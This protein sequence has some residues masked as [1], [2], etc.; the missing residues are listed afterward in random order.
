MHSMLYLHDGNAMPAR[1]RGRRGGFVRRR[2]GRRGRRCSAASGRPAGRAALRHRATGCATVRRATSAAVHRTTAHQPDCRSMH[3]PALR[4]ALHHPSVHPALHHPFVHL[5]AMHYPRMHQ[6]VR[7]RMRAGRRSLGRRRLRLARQLAA[8]AFINR[9]TTRH[10]YARR[11]V[12][13]FL[14]GS[15]CPWPE[16]VRPHMKRGSH[17]RCFCRPAL[18]GH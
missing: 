1:H 15:L 12:R 14:F 17:G 11:V 6:R 3:H 10:F 9:H 18:C 8:G 7:R 16:I 13:L 5:A 4:P 2:A